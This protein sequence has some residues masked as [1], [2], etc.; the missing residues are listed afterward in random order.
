M[1]ILAAA[2]GLICLV[3][4]LQAANLTVSLA[5]IPGLAV[6]DGSGS[7]EGAMPRLLAI[8]DEYYEGGDFDFQVFPFGR[9]IQ[10]VVTGKADVHAPLIDTGTG[11][12][13]DFQYISEPLL[14]VTFVIY[15]RRD[16][17]L[18]ASSDLSSLKVET[19]IGHSHF[20]DFA[21]DEVTSIEIGLKKLVNGRTDAFIMEQDAVDGLIKAQGMSDL[22][23]AKY[24]VW[25]ST[26]IV[27][28]GPEGDAL[29]AALSAA[30]AKAKTDERYAVAAANV[31]AP[32]ED[33]QP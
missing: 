33:W 5:E 13:P 19:M 14:D 24:A 27:P 15:S 25:D 22:H 32:F 1:K 21:V 18:D 12:P 26:L 16:A 7:A 3:T 10:N 28:A 17:P 4:P 23:R 31:H 6:S 2:L 29:N 20:F 8:V 30:V 11:S 9:S